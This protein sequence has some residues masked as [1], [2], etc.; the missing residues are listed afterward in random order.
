MSVP[1]LDLPAVTPARTQPASGRVRLLYILAASHS[2]STLLAML[3]GSH[4]EMGTVGELNAAR[5]GDAAG[6]RCSCGSAIGRCAFWARITNAMAARGLAF[7]ITHAGTDVR[8]GAPWPAARLLR[9]L[10]RGR[11]LELAREAALRCVPRWRAHVRRIHRVNAALAASVSVE[12]GKPVVVDSSKIG[13]RLKYLLRNPDLDVRVVRL[14]RDGR[15]VALSYM[16]SANFAD[17][18]DPRL[19]GGGAG[20]LARAERAP[21]A[22][23]AREWRRCQEEAESI[24]RTLHP[25]RWMEVRYEDLCADPLGTVRAVARFAGVDPARATIDFRGHEHHVVGNGMR[26]DSTADIRADERWRDVLDG[27]ALEVFERVAGAARARLGYRRHSAALTAAAAS[28]RPECS[29]PLRICIVAHFAYGAF[30][31]GSRGHIGGVER[32]TTMLARW[33]A[34]RGHDVSLIT[35]DEGQADAQRVDGVRLLK[36]CSE[37]SGVPG[38]RFFHPRWTSL[39]A[40]L[41]AAEADVYYHNCAEYVTGQ[42]ALW[43]R[44]NGRRFV[45]SVASDPEC[46]RALPA[47]HTRRERV[48]YRYGLGRADLV[49]AQTRAQQRLLLQ[50][51]GKAST[52]V[53]MPCPVPA[54]SAVIREDTAPFRVLWI[55]KTTWDKRPDLFL[56]L[57]RRCAEIDFDFVGPIYGDH[58]SQRVAAGL[59]DCPNVRVHGAIPRADVADRYRAASLVCS[60]S[61]TEGF[62]NT[63]LEAWSYGVPVVST[64]DPDGIIAT[65]GLGAACA[66]VAQLAAAIRA[67]RASPDSLRAASANA[68]E[69][70][71]HNHAFERV[72]PQLEEAFARAAGRVTAHAGRVRL[73]REPVP[74]V[75]RQT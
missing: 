13:I 74:G 43:C 59:R 11:V 7:D 52:V 19:R 39:V 10:H 70:F 42:I 64:V 53:P 2:G 71:L 65:R 68:R 14:I 9:P 62:P 23:A 54:D 73:A 67:F 47:L 17:A 12:T 51:F 20:D 48:L 34:G 1:T 6:Y 50:E 26:L 30:T 44:R 49:I 37:R 31:G 58:Y 8:S 22:L 75:A 40:A 18:A 15:G 72:M 3:L 38:L 46:L 28:T 66:D 69:Y 27:E 61:G 29:P 57:A 24:R 4:P 60:T 25:S 41:R 63:F 32:Q 5:V 45:F 16:D 55:A 21:M 35:W 33:L 56:E 36:V